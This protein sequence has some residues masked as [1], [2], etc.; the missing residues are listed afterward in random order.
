MNLEVLAAVLT[1]WIIAQTGFLPP[2]PPQIALVR[3]E[4]MVELAF[5]AHA[6]EGNVRA[7][8]DRNTETIYLREGWDPK[9]LR[10]RSE[11]LHELVHHVQ[12]FNKVPSQCDAARERDAYHLQ[13]AWLIEQGI[14]D[15]YSFLEINELMVV[16]LSVCRDRDLD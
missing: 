14:Q 10:S 16:L 9:D 12:N 11:L 1:G 3:K 5:G 13:F 8:Y 15:P 4:R 6:T 2:P 7:L